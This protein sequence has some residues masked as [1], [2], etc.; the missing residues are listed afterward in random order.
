MEEEEE[1]IYYEDVSPR[2]GDKPEGEEEKGWW[3]SDP[4]WLEP[5][6]EDEGEVSYLNGILS[7]GHSREGGRE[8]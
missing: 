4:S 3:T 2:R 1:F 5:E 7:E 6:E 8:K